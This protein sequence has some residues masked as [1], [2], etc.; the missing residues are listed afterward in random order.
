M[1]RDSFQAYV[2][3]NR[4]RFIEELK[5][6]V[7]QPSVSAQGLGLQEMADLVQARLERLGASARSSSTITTTCSRP[8]R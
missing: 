2:E 3:Q 6:F 4:E 5:T 1:I 8:S 7:R